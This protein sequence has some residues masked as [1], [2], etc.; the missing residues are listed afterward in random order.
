MTSMHKRYI[1]SLASCLVIFLLISLF[2]LP[3]GVMLVSAEDELEEQAYTVKPFYIV[4]P[5]V[6][7]VIRDLEFRDLDDF[8]EF[9]DIRPSLNKERSQPSAIVHQA[10]RAMLGQA[11]LPRMALAGLTRFDIGEQVDDPVAMHLAVID[12]EIPEVSEKETSPGTVPAST[13]EKETPGTSTG[14]TL[15]N[16]AATPE[17]TPRPAY[18]PG[19]TSGSASVDEAADAI[20]RSLITNQMSNSQIISRVY[21]WTRSQIRYSAGGSQVYLTG[22]MDGL[23]YRRGNCY[24]RAFV[25]VALL[26]RAGVWSTYHFEYRRMHAWAQVG[27]YVLDVGFNIFM[28]PI[29]SLV[30]TRRDGYYIYRET[31]S[32]I[33]SDSSRRVVFENRVPIPYSTIYQVNSNESS[34]Y[35]NLTYSD[36]APQNGEIRDHYTYFYSG[37]R[38]V[39]KLLVEKDQRVEPV[40]QIIFVGQRDSRT[41]RVPMTKGNAT[42]VTQDQ[43]LDG[44]QVP[45]TG[46]DGVVRITRQLLSVD[47]A[48][49]APTGWSAETS[50]TETEMIPYSVYLYVAPTPTPSPTPP[51]ATPTPSPT[52]PPPEEPTPPPSEEPTPP[53][54]EEP[55]PP[56]AE[57]PT[58]P[59]DPNPTDPG[60]SPEPGDEEPPDEEP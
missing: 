53:P 27:S 15:T 37:T 46:R 1:S 43:N 7:D 2:I 30:D 33:P 3:V 13:T 56:P 35:N 50:V 51:P 10:S 42:V 29:S 22:A 31:A 34:V 16:P 8:D 12:S 4:R 25:L 58:P 11:H 49:G 60:T 23:R 14:P 57:E 21:S 47:S 5:E 9:L 19:G 41:E 17:P 24:T 59:P 6:E 45:N 32:E 54:A 44:K 26:R 40:H 28:R 52:P 36:V 39:R 18:E 20:L 48:T 55:T 38:L